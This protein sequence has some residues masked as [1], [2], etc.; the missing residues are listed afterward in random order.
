MYLF[1]DGVKC[2]EKT[3]VEGYNKGD[4]IRA[5]GLMR[6][7]HSGWDLKADRFSTA[8]EGGSGV[9][10]SG[11]AHAKAL[12]MTEPFLFFILLKFLLSAV[13]DSWNFQNQAPK[14]P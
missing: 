5:G 7:W 11:N 4:G 6:K 14:L 10:E 1:T 9:P 8:V 2:S 12:E 3:L 13:W